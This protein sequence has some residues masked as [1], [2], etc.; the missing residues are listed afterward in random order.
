[1]QS[2]LTVKKYFLSLPTV[3]ITG[4][5]A[6]LAGIFF[7]DFSSFNWSLPKPDILMEYG[8]IARNMADGLGFSYTWYNGAGIPVTLSTAFMPPG[9]VFI[10]YLVISIFGYTHAALV[11]IFLLQVIMGVA[12]IW[13]VGK[14]A[15]ALFKSE[16]ISGA[17]RWIIALYPPFVYAAMSF[18]VTAAVMFVGFVVLFAS[19]K[20][21]DAISNKRPATGASILLGVS[22]G[23][24]MLLRGEGPVI[25]LVIFIV[26]C[27][28]LR[29]ELKRYAPTLILSVIIAL[30]IIA[31]WTIRNYMIFDRFIPVSSNGSL[32]FYRGNNELSTGSAWTESGEPLWISNELWQKTEPHLS[33]GV[34]FENIYSD[35]YRDAAF[36]WIR[37]N[38]GDA[39]LLSLKKGLIF[40]TFDVRYKLTGWVYYLLHSLVL[41]T[42]IYGAVCIR[43]IRKDL[44]TASR[45][46]LTLIVVW[47]ITSLIV[48]MVFL[49]LTRFQILTVALAVPVAAYGI[50]DVLNKR[51]FLNNS[52]S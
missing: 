52:L 36:T 13:L 16:I 11:T 21:A 40:L 17:A 19:V 45:I 43:R 18:G 2:A 51:F 42:I 12:C 3:I 6:R 50:G 28:K 41:I 14:I 38:P 20:F 32:N 8:V 1:M 34:I 15:D 29:T 27:I 37:A 23:A 10:D 4:L 31:P 35:N 30:A 46:G 49:P 22:S 5:I 26:L 33:E 25:I 9:L 48:A 44:S 47:S 7:I 24:L 39:L